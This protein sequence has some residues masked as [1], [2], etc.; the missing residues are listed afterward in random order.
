MNE[1]LK[2]TKHG[3]GV[4]IVL[5]SLLASTTTAGEVSNLRL[6]KLFSDNMVI[7]RDK[8]IK[9]WGWAKPG[10]MVT[11]Q[12]GKEKKEA[13]VGPETKVNVF[14]HEKDYAGLGRWEVTF[15][16]REASADPHKLVVTAGDE[17][18]ELTNV[19]FGEVWV[20]SGQSN[21]AFPLGKTNGSDMVKM[22]NNPNLRL[23]S[24][25]GNEQ[26]SLQ[27]DIRPEAIDTLSG[28]WDVSSPET[29]KDFSAIG[30]VFGFYL[31][32][33]LDIP[34]GLIKNAR[35]GASIESMVPVYKFDEHP[36]AK[37]HADYIKKRM[38]E[39]DPE[40][41]ADEIWG[42]KKARAKSKGNPEPPRPDPNDLRSWNVPGKSPSHMGSVH[43]GFFG[44]FK[45][46]NIKGV[47]FHQ[48]HNNQM[49]SAL[50]PK[51]YRVLTR[52][53]IEGWREEFND[54][55]L[56]VAVIGFNAGGTTQNE[57]NFEA[58]SIDGGPWIR[59]A[60]RLG[61]ADVESEA[62]TAFL[63][64]YD[65]QVPGL[66]P[67]KKREH[68]WRAA[69]WAL[70]NVYTEKGNEWKGCISKLISAEPAGDVFVL[71]F[72]K[73]VRTDD[74][75]VYRRD[76]ILEGFS[77]AGEDGKFYKAYARH[78]EWEGNYW[79][80][81]HREIH[82]WSPLVEKPVA[83]RYAWANSPMGNLY[84]DGG[85][86]R[87][88]PSFRTDDW[89]LP[90]NPEQGERALDRGQQ[91]ERKADA[92]TRLEY[93]KLEEAKRAMEIYERLKTLGQSPR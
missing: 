30:Y 31:Q 89:D 71:K 76:S 3:I 47:L 74:G 65:V 90:I 37:A 87:P 55:L 19:V 57:Q 13:K 36:L 17:K 15:D 2:M 12:L 22:A 93:R 91:R 48:G 23:F 66:H 8:P 51:L 44:V 70:N 20:L 50:R 63:P 33:A 82:V 84:H 9:I 92:Q 88:F 24:I 72:D 45:G 53:M 5:V 52:L 16:P 83:V 35:G 64:A 79:K 43:N 56:P 68:G 39:F 27:D 69:L 25:T 80:H 4:L 29:A 78:A 67:R 62:L 10:D 7:Q 42:R 85:Q 11:V 86:D 73:R 14:G 60:Q 1:V 58:F 75:K 81:G 61:V 6:H 77:I 40:A 46:Y 34:V 41:E 28:G 49:S 21:M 32:P 26:A 38:A 18:V 59:E 54:P